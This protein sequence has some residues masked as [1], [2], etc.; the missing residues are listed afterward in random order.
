MTK[1]KIIFITGGSASGKTTLALQIKEAMGDKA[2]LIS[3]DMFY[4]P[5][6]AKNVNFDTPEAFDWDLIKKVC[7]ELKEGKT[8]KI[9]VYSFETSSRIGWE[10]VVPQ[11]VIIFEGLFTFYDYELS[12]S[13]DFKIFVDTPSDTRLARRIMRDVKERGREIT[14]VIKRWEDDVQPSFVKY[15]K[16]LKHQSDIIIPWVKVKENAIKAIIATIN[17]L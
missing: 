7:L 17:V 1:P 9:P 14:S 2:T 3:Q 8:T 15:I 4:K 12:K 11:K 13:A 5:T 10:E 16:P 6:Q